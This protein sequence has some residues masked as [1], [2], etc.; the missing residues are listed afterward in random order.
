MNWATCPRCATAQPRSFGARRTKASIY[1]K[2]NGRFLP[3]TAPVKTVAVA[4][5]ERADFVIDFREHSGAEIVLKNEAF[6]F[7]Q[8]RVSR[9]NAI[10]SS[11]L[12]SL[13]C[14]VPKIAEASAVNTRRLTIDESKSGP[15]ETALMLL[16][17]TPWHHPVTEK[18]V[19]NTAEIWSIINPTDD[20]HPMHLHLV[21]FQILDRR[22]YDAF[23]YATSDELRYTGPTIPPEPYEAGWKDTVQAHPGMVTRIIIRFEGYAGRH[24]CALPRSCG[25]RRKW[26]RY[27]SVTALSDVVGPVL[28]TVEYHVDAQRL[29]EFIKTMHEYGRVRRATAH[30]NGEFVETLRSQTVTLK[31]LL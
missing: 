24:G 27:F 19:L 4:P 10:D 26:S 22:N 18:P 17:K 9:E 5:G 1:Q 20:S 25:A 8:F 30:R 13:L 31:L 21:R 14:P 3:A 23:A 12:P 11:S 29:P 16:N 6:E 28:V 7:L 15:G 2:E